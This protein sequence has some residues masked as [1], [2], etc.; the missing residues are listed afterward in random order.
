MMSELLQEIR[1]RILTKLLLFSVAVSGPDHD[2]GLLPRSLSVIFNSIDGRL[3]SR[4]DLKPQ[5][6]RDYSR[7]T[8]DQQAAEVTSKKNLLRPFK[9]VRLS[10]LY[11]SR[12]IC[13]C[14]IQ[15]YT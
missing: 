8:P 4:N 5:R 10:S 11:L 12:P 14:K 6:C 13:K 9:E 2:S 3:Y 7:L 1:C 15:S